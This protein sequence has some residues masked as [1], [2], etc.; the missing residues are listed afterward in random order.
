MVNCP[1]TLPPLQSDI[2]YV[3]TAGG[4]NLKCSPISHLAAPLDAT[5]MC[6]VGTL[7]RRAI[8]AKVPRDATDPRLYDWKRVLGWSLLNPDQQASAVLWWVWCAARLASPPATAH[9]LCML[10]SLL[11]SSGWLAASH[12]LVQTSTGCWS[13]PQERAEKALSYGPDGGRLSS[14]HPAL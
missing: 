3:L 9:K 5:V 2:L 14:R 1:S 12:T 8:L 7:G 6:G 11:H 4:H 10:A 13:L